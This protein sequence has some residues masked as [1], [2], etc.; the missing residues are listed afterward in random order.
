MR[1]LTGKNNKTKTGSSNNERL[2][3][4]YFFLKVCTRS[5]V[6]GDCLAFGF[7]LPVN[8]YFRGSLR[9]GGT[10]GFLFPHLKGLS[11][12]CFI[13][14]LGA[15]ALLLWRSLRSHLRRSE[16]VWWVLICVLLFWLVADNLVGNVS[17]LF[18]V[19]LVVEPAGG[20]NSYS[21]LNK[22]QQEQVI[23]DYRDVLTGYAVVIFLRGIVMAGSLY[24]LITLLAY[25]G[26]S[27]SRLPSR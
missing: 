13:A 23:S 19:S 9:F 25:Q 7:M 11:L 14:I 5:T 21:G 10:A 6:I 16:K 26:Q 18:D 27:T 17:R 22:A 8:L 1:A 3:H 12:I 24:I 15:L 2:I 20:L 4:F